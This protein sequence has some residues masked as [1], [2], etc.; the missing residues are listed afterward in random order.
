MT[1]EYIRYSIS[2][3]RQD[4]FIKGYT[5]AARQLD[6]SPYCLGYELSH[7]EEAPEQFILRIEWTSKKDH[8][9]GFRNSPDFR[10]FFSAIQPFMVGIEEM[11]HYSVT[12]VVG[13]KK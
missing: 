7:C 10:D 3:N 6:K 8:L 13:E 11:N 9:E 2:G 4:E 1:I 5:E 12:K